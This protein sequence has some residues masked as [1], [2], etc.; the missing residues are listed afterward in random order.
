MKKVAKAIRIITLAPII[1]YVLITLIFFLRPGSFDLAQYILAIIFLTVLPLLGYPMQPYLK[2]FKD[3]GR[4]GQRTLAMIMAVIGYILGII[5]ALA[6]GTKG[7]L[8]V[9][10]LTYLFSGIL[11]LFV[12][13]VLKV[14][15]SGHAGGVSGPLAVIIMVFGPVGLF[16]LIVLGLMCW[17]SLVLKRHT[18]AQLIAGSIIPLVALVIAVL[19][20]GGLGI[21]A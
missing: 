14:R 18:L 5:V 1:A 9:I 16:G 21:A 6:T 3:K 8:L 7:I 20:C 10:Y 4:D 17:A 2:P 11:L 15:A 12:N 13:K 19:I